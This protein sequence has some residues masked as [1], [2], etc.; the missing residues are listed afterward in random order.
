M[1]SPMQVVLPRQPSRP[2]MSMRPVSRPAPLASS[3]SAS[4]ERIPR[5]HGIPDGVGTTRSLA[6]GHADGRHGPTAPRE[7]E[8]SPGARTRAWRPGRLPGMPEGIM[9]DGLPD[10]ATCLASWRTGDTLR[11]SSLGCSSPARDSHASQAPFVT[12]VSSGNL[13]ATM[14]S[15]L[16]RIVADPAWG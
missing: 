7:A 12:A 4:D 14:R 2:L 1:S 9:C 16:R 5:R 13:S 8:G 11:M 6:G 3:S 10:A 15:N